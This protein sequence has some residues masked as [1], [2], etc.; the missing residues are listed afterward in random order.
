MMQSRSEMRRTPCRHLLAAFAALFLLGAAAQAAPPRAAPLTAPQQQELKRIQGYLNG[1]KS[2]Q[3]RFEQ[4]AG[5]GATA[6][7]TLYLLRPGDMRLVYDPP[8]GILIVAS[9]GQL[10][11]YD[12][13]VQQVTDTYTA[14]TPAWFL[15]RDDIRLNGDVTV[16]RFERQDDVLHITLVQTAHPDQGQVTLVLSDRPLELRQWTVVDAQQKTVTVTL[17]DPHFGVP[18]SPQL[19]YWTPPQAPAFGK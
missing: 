3:S 13:T 11:Y 18:L 19:F 2:L 9:N 16:T 12:K 10:H 17:D 6:S 14:N 1:I 4:V 7:G 8:S 5:T 15:L